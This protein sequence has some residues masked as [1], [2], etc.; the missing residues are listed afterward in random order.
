MGHVKGVALHRVAFGAPV[1]RPAAPQG[2]IERAARG[3]R[4]LLTRELAPHDEALY[5]S[6]WRGEQ[7]VKSLAGNAHCALTTGNNALSGGSTSW[8]RARRS[9]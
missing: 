2:R 3:E 8:S 7:M 6:T 4:A 1:T 5:F 9:G